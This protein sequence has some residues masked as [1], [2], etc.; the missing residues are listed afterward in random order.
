MTKENW[1]QR[2]AVLVPDAQA[3]GMIGVIR[4]LGKAGYLVHA[5]SNERDALGLASNFTSKPAIN[6]PYR[7]GCFI[8]WL[9]TYV[10]ENK[11][12]LIIPS[13]GFLHAIE[14]HFD[15]FSSLLPVSRNKEITYRAFSKIDV[16]RLF[17]SA[18]PELRIAE[19]LPPSILLSRSNNLP[20]PG[21]LQ[22]LGYPLYVK[23][24][25]KYCIDGSTSLLKRIGDPAIAI[26]EIEK[27]LETHEI[28]LVQ[29]FV[30]GSKAATAFCISN[31][32]ILAKSSVLGLRT[33]PHTGGMMSLRM[34]ISNPNLEI[35]C[36]GWLEYLK[37]EGVAMVECK[38]DPAQ[39][40]FWFIELNSRYWGYLHLDLFSGVD[41]PR[42]QADAFFGVKGSGQPAR[43]TGI[44][45]RH[46]VP[47]DVGCLRSLLTD[48]EVK[49]FSKIKACISFLL[50]T[51]DPR[52]RADLL[53]PGDRKLYFLQLKKFLKEIRSQ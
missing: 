11:I 27:S 53:F 22:L 2:H 13:E 24:D 50:D 29:G 33:N 32:E 25:A 23:S 5:S 6:P 40:K 21:Q 12:E 38:W 46:L 17:E 41:M 49:K 35:L 16:A 36:E 48:P 30:R 14:P 45:T 42:I 52:I 26:R 51:I 39:N 15:E 3:L 9:R 31:G 1:R 10:N 19:C 43:R 18:D 28:I 37:W 44:V 4:S 20:T 7:D 8:K 34:S 47:G